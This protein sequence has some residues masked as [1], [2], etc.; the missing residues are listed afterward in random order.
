VGDT[1]GPVMLKLLLTADCPGGATVVVTATRADGGGSATLTATV[2]AGA[3]AGDLVFLRW[4][5]HDTYPGNPCKWYT[6][7]TNAVVTSGTVS[8]QIVNDGPSWRDS[9]GIHV[10]HGAYSPFACDCDL[11][12]AQAVD[13]KRDHIGVLWHGFIMESG[14]LRVKARLHW[15]LPW[16]CD[17]IVDEERAWRSPSIQPLSTGEVLFAATDTGENA[18][19]LFLSRDRGRTWSE[20]MAALGSDLVNVDLCELAGTVYAV[21]YDEDAAW[22]EWSSDSG[23]S[24]REFR[25]S[26]T[27]KEV[28]A[29]TED[30]RLSIEATSTGELHVTVAGTLYASR[31]GGETWAAV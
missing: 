17:T 5:P 21:G 24:M 16:A 13:V 27:R 8:C 6:D 28:A 26:S 3:V 10:T 25:D 15:T 4:G 12:T 14:S 23:A 31:D 2:P 11:A 20:L 9:D 18:S 19:A 22:F 7:V 30:D 1:I 29:A